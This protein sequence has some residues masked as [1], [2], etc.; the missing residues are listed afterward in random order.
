M[1]LNGVGAAFV[2]P[3]GETGLGRIQL[4]GAIESRSQEFVHARGV[5][6][7]ADGAERQAKFATEAVLLSIM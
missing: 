6:E 3:A 2:S 1:E 4:A 5:G 7:L